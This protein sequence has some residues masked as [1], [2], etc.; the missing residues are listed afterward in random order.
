LY[1]SSQGCLAAV[2]THEQCVGSHSVTCH[3]TE[4][5]FPPLPQPKLVLDLETPK[6][7]K[8]ELTQLAGYTTRWYICPKTVTHPSTNRAQR[9]LTSFMRRTPITTTPRRQLGAFV[10]LQTRSR[11][12]NKEE[13]IFPLFSLPF[14]PLSF[15]PLRSTTPPPIA[16]RGSGER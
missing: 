6:G 11:K 3:P 5:T 2:G 1:S 12:L 13:A 7:C 16:A 4:V 10:R 8:A 9:G 14:R 15:L